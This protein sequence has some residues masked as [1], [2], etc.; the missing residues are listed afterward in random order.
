[1]DRRLGKLAPGPA[2]CR[3]DPKDND[4]KVDARPPWF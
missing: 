4:V 3:N 1:M 2:M